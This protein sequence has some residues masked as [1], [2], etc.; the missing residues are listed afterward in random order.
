MEQKRYALRIWL[1]HQKMIWAEVQVQ[2]LGEIY[3]VALQTLKLSQYCS[4]EDC[5]PARDFA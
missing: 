3:F 2:K 5:V 4:I 1:S